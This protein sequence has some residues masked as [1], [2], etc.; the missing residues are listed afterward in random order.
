MTKTIS[1]G[2]VVLGLQRP[3]PSPRT[4]PRRRRAAGV[5]DMT[6]MGPMS[7]KVTKEDKKG[8]D[9]LYKAIEDGMKKGDVNAMADLVDSR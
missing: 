8:V 9:E 1:V 7:R 3:W 6:K 5:P 2:L 4:R